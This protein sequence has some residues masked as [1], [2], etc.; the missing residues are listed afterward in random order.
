MVVMLTTLP[1]LLFRMLYI[2]G[3]F[4]PEREM[5]ACNMEDLAYSNIP[6]AV[7]IIVNI[8]I[9]LLSVVLLVCTAAENPNVPV[10]VWVAVHAVLCLIH[11]ILVWYVYRHVSR[12]RRRQ[13]QDYARFVRS[14]AQARLAYICDF[15]NTLAWFVWLLVVGFYWVQ[16]EDKL[17]PQ[18]AP[19]LYWWFTRVYVAYN[20]LFIMMRSI[21]WFPCILVILKYIVRTVAGQEGSSEADLNVLPKYRFYM[22]R[23]LEKPSIGAGVMVPMDTSSGVPT[24]ERVV[25]PQDSVC[26]ICL[27]SYDDGVE[28][29][30]LPCNHHFHA[31]CSEKWLKINAYC[32]V[33]K[34]NIL[35]RSV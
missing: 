26:C 31:T 17:L 33:C 24:A 16:P 7:E 32:P 19:W 22:L 27:C 9:A 18:N 23:N 6:I 25:L 13:L 28:L 8:V 20:N 5:H 1:V 15:F 29:H 10:R 35:T 12:R 30:A 14:S 4:L 2:W 21:C 34:Y 11:V 3:P